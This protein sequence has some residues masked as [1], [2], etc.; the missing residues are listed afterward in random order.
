MPCVHLEE[1]AV[2]ALPPEAFRARLVVTVLL[3]DLQ[4]CHLR[5]KAKTVVI[6]ENTYIDMNKIKHVLKDSLTLSRKHLP[7]NSGQ[8]VYCSSSLRKVLE[9][10][11]PGR[12]WRMREKDEDDN[13]L[14][15]WLALMAN[16]W[17]KRSTSRILKGTVVMH[18]LHL[19]NKNT[20]GIMSYS[21]I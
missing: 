7:T 10:T 19:C 15:C 13:Q 2:G 14:K 16:Q 6:Q 20:Q 11:K 9:T 4:V 18:L 8:S 3:I 12:W 1:G 5:N 21:T 17:H